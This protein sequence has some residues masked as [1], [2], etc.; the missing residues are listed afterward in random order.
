[1]VEVVCK[2]W[3]EICRLV[4][5]NFGVLVIVIGCVVQIEFEIFVVMVE[6]MCVVGNYEKM[7]F[8]IWQ[9]M[10]VFD[11]IGDIEKVQV[12]DIMLVKEIVG[13]L[14]DGFGC[15][16]V[17]VQVQNGCDY[18]C[19]F[20]I[21]FYGWGNLCL[22]LVGVVIDQIKCLCDCGFNEVVLIG[23]DLISWGVDLLGQLKL[24]DLVMCILWLVLDLLCLC[25][26]S[27]DSIEV[28]E[29]LMLVIVIELCLMLYLYLFLQVGDDMILKW[30]KCCY[31]CDDVICFCEDVCCLCLGI[32]FGVD[33]IVGFLIEIEVMFENSL[34]LVDDCGLIFLYVFLYFVCKGMFVV[35]MFKVQ[36]FQI[37]DRVV[38]LW[39]KGDVVLV[40]YLGV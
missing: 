4:W 32:V 13:Y 20:C 2:V 3:Q 11:L 27:I 17:Y 30:M 29:N 8:E 1:M 40:L 31:L 36:G 6:V 7:L 16:C 15:Y 14:I 24:G 26:S 5:E 12:D 35:W 10:Q 37:K 34:K 23:V 28:D 21:I 33:I 18:C 39:V 22:V 19:I 38:C 9:W 25:I